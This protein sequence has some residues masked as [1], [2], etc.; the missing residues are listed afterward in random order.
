MPTLRVMA[1]LGECMLLGK[2]QSFVSGA[3]GW[4]W[5]H[6]G[7]DV[8]DHLHLLLQHFIHRAAT[9]GTNRS[10]NVH[11]FASVNGTGAPSQVLPL[12]T[13]IVGDGAGAGGPAGPSVQHA[14]G[15]DAVVQLASSALGR[16]APL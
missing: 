14:G 16:L 2:I 11:Q 5:S 13:I 12:L 1:Q 9:E 6:G 8:P 15:V 10:H 7:R 3:H 4:M